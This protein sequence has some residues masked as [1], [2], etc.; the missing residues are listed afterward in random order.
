MSV[1]EPGP[2]EVH[3]TTAA[4]GRTYF[5]QHVVILDGS[6]GAFLS[7][8]PTDITHADQIGGTGTLTSQ[9][10]SLAVGLAL[11]EDAVTRCR[12]EMVR[13]DDALTPRVLT[14]GD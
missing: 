11:L 14:D 10:R 7:V 4:I 3:V 13:C 5:G 1:S 2:D 6:R 8:G 12:R 9:R